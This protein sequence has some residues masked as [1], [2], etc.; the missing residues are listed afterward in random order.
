MSKIGIDIEKAKQILQQ[1]GLVAIPTETVYGL[2]ANGL[3]KNAVLKIFE[4]KNRPHF[5]PLIIHTNSIEKIKLWVNDFPEWA[6]Q[7]ADAFWPG[8]LTLLLPKKNIV[9]DLVTAGLPQVAVRIPNHKLTL[10]LL[11]SLDFPLAAPSANPFGYVSPTTAAHVAA[12]LQNK[13][14]YIL[15]GDTCDVGIESTIVGFENNSITVYRLGGLAIEDIEQ[16]VGKVNVQVNQSS[17]PTAPGMLKSHY[18]PTKPLFIGD[19]GDFLKNNPSKKIG[20]IS[21]FQNYNAEKK[22]LKILSPTKDLK[23]AAHN[24]FA[25]IR[26]LDASDAEIIIAEKFPDNFLGRAINDRLQRASAK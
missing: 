11:E 7:L 2:A 4:A 13:V 9:P 20:I 19:V 25:A 23:E 26:D 12:Q 14:D 3:D 16:V 1:G 24:L 5:D 18:A 21:F 8:P 6:Q 10:Q 17:N 22:D 15:D